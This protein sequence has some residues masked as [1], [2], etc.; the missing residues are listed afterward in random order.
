MDLT[1][2]LYLGA[3]FWVGTQVLGEKQK[4]CCFD[5]EFLVRGIGIADD[6]ILDDLIGDENTDSTLLE[7]VKF[8]K[9]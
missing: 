2:A 7:M 5:K 1:K 9:N 3:K 8:K 4:Y 6:D